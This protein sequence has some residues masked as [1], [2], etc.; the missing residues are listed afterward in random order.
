MKFSILSALL[1]AALSPAAVAQEP[2]ET[3]EP[4]RSSSGTGYV[5]ASIF[6]SSKYLGSADAEAR[7]LPYLS[8]E[9]IKGF[10]LSGP[11]LSYRLVETGTG[12]GF[13]K[14]SLRA[15]PS[16]RF[17]SGRDSGDSPALAGIEDVGT[18]F[19]LGGY[20]RSTVGPVS[21]S[22]N[23]GQDIAG[24]HGGM[25]ADAS[26]GTFVPLGKVFLRPSLT[27]SWA[28]R[29]HNR[30]FFGVTD[31]QAISSGLSRYEAGAGIYSYSAG[32]LCSAELNERYA[33]TFIGSYRRFTGD[34]ADSPI[35]NAED[36]SKNGFFTA[37]SIARKFDT[38]NW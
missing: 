19:P 30:S 5:G 29:S 36:G 3:P 11:A 37:V 1:L 21:L 24:G 28:D 20:I 6:Y 35:L 12:R 22:F 18:A 17:Q 8:F 15:G 31:D 32:I 25:T 10:D 23:A 7:V 2:F 33:L 13:G 38:S 4:A 26:I 34:A 27:V 9:D 16:I 14:W